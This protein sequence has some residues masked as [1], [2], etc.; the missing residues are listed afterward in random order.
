MIYV[1]CHVLSNQ[2]L[3]INK[4]FNFI[5]KEKNIIKIDYK[6]LTQYFSFHQNSFNI[7]SIVVQ[8]TAEKIHS[9]HLQDPEVLHITKILLKYMET[10][11]S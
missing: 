5:N 7:S 2:M 4:R 1:T 6:N 8:Y 9:H 3:L 11:C 10:N